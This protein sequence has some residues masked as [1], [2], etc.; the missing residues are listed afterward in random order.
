MLLSWSTGRIRVMH[1]ESWVATSADNLIESS[2]LGNEI[3]DDDSWRDA[4]PV[5]GR[6]W[7]LSG[8]T[9]DRFVGCI[10]EAAEASSPWNRWYMDEHV[11][12]HGWSATYDPARCE[13]ILAWYRDPLGRQRIESL[14][15]PPRP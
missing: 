7:H 5:G 9:T 15:G 3:A 4:V 2:A 10:P 13:V 14:T 12:V 1:V 8:V 6:S 11:A